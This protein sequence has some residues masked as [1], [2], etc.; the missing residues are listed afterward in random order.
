M[1][2]EEMIPADEFCM[3]HNIELSFI[4]ALQQSGLVEIIHAEEKIFVPVNE[5]N[6]LEKLVRLY[7]EMDI[8]LEGI[9][10]ITYLLQRIHDLQQQIVQLNSRL[11]MYETE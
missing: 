3:H 5:L 9:E 7:Y 4:Y 10:T 8:N 11:G 6:R 1:Q 2:T